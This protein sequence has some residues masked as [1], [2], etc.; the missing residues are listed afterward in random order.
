MDENEAN[1]RLKFSIVKHKKRTL[2]IL[3][4]SC[5]VSCE[6]HLDSDIDVIGL[7]CQEILSERMPFELTSPY[8][9]FREGMHHCDQ[10][11]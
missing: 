3:R 7:K 8:R 5:R 10:Y 4:P 2:R 6:Q 1:L 11:M 9:P